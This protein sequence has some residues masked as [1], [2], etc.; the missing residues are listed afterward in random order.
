MPVAASARTRSVA[1]SEP[2]NASR[3]AT[4]TSMGAARRSASSGVAWE[5]PREAIP[6]ASPNPPASTKSAAQI[7]QSSSRG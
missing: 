3:T 6:A 5:T 7:R 1:V 2:A 4:S